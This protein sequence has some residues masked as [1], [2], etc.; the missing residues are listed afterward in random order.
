MVL[1]TSPTKGAVARWT[2]VI[3]VLFQAVMM[4]SAAAASSAWITKGPPRYP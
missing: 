3:R 2:V 1:D 4:G